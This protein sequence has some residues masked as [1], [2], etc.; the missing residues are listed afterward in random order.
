MML[1][2]QVGQCFKARPSPNLDGCSLLAPWSTR[3]SRHS[4]PNRK[5]PVGLIAEQRSVEV[6]I[7]RTSNRPLMGLLG[8]FGVATVVR[9]I[10]CV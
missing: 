9:I 3:Y 7:R 8:L 10:S 1:L 2:A 4:V 6:G 5:E